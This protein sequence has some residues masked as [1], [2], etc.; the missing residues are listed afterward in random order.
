MS[1]PGLTW[2]NRIVYS[3]HELSRNKLEPPPGV[4][5]NFI[6]QLSRPSLVQCANVDTIIS[7]SSLSWPV[8]SSVQMGDL[9]CKLVRS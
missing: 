6:P 1:Y 7:R 4:E 8:I 9:H 5:L 3:E 2:V